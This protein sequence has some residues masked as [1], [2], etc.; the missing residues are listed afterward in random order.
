MAD[1]H[2]FLYL[3]PIRGLTDA[4]FR[5]IFCRHFAGFDA[6]MAPFIN[7]QRRATYDDAMLADVLPGNNSGPPLI[8]QLLHNDAQS[9]L[10]LATRLGELGYREINWNLGCPAP[11]V[12][13]KGRGSGLLPHPERIIDLLAEVLPRLESLGLRLSLKTRLGYH[14]RDELPRLLPHLDPLPLTEIIIHA[15]L[16]R[17]LYHG[18]TDPEGFAI[19]AGASRHRL[20]YNG[21]ITSAAIFAELARRF[22]AVERWMIGRGAL[23]DPFLAEDIKGFPPQPRERRL[24]RLAAFHDELFHFY[25][26]RLSGPAHILGRLKQLWNYLLESFPE[27]PRLGKKLLKSTTLA[28]YGE[29]VA[30]L[31]DPSSA[32]RTER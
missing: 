5:A 18:E 22:P 1:S 32:R 4:P 20:V 19:C 15:R 28:S 2:P 26:Q 31:L 24:A 9:F 30:A 7:P 3:A 8:P 14:Q 27:E 17:Q 29:A 16:G 13:K 12:A 6:T 10:V 21:D 23:A 11:M 25:R